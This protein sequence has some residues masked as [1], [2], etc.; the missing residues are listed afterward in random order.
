MGIGRFAI[1]NGFMV[2]TYKITRDTKSDPDVRGD[3]DKERNQEKGGCLDWS[4]EYWPEGAMYGYQRKFAVDYQANRFWDESADWF[5]E[6]R[7]V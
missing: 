5:G 4:V 2:A 3:T 1:S 7:I 6:E